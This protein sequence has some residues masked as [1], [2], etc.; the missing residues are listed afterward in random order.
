[1]YCPEKIVNPKV[2]YRFRLGSVGEALE[3]PH[4][5]FY[6]FSRFGKKGP[7]HNRIIKTYS[8]IEQRAI[9]YNACSRQ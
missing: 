3:S 6:P 8:F 7:V 9:N 2:R 4:D 5:N 1:M